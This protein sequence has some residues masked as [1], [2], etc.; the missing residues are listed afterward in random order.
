[1]S[2]KASDQ[3]IGPENAILF[4]ALL[5]NFY[6]LIQAA[7]IHTSQNPIVVQSLQEFIGTVHLLASDE[8]RLT[9]RIID[10]R[11]FF[12]EQKVTYRSENANLIAKVIKYFEIRGLHGL[13]L[14]TTLQL[15][16]RNEL[17]L[18]ATLLNTS[19]RKDNPEQWLEQ[20]IQKMN[21]DWVEILHEA[22]SRGQTADREPNATNRLSPPSQRR[23][24]SAR[25]GS[26]KNAYIGALTAL[27][28]IATQ[29][30]SGRPGGVRKALRTVQNMVDLIMEDE[31]VLLG[32]S[33]IRDFDDYTYVHSVNVGILAMTLGARIGLSRDSLEMIGICGL[34][35]DIGKTEIPLEIINKPGKLTQDEF[36]EIQK[37]VLY[38]VRLILKLR[39]PRDLKSK[40]II[41]PFE[42]HLKY[43]LSG[44]PQTKH[45]KPLSL[46]GRIISIADVYDALTSPRI[47]RDKE[48]SP[49]HALEIMVKKG[50]T[51][52]DP[53]LLKVFIKM[54]GIYPI[55][56]LLKLDS[57]EI[58]LVTESSKEIDP[59]R[60]RV[61]LLESVSKNKFKRGKTV[62]L[63]EKNFKSSGYKR[64]IVG[65]Y[66]PCL[67][68]IQPAQYLI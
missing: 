34:F 52:F 15:S 56:T 35:H 28:E 6:R 40:I 24:E 51:D 64:S 68:G 12:Q 42:H 61:V 32:L 9:I 29:V 10:G 19:E 25:I 62:S 65:S 36:E 7:K 63:S 41:A 30:T 23:P 54:I 49:N 13:S 5:A 39:A 20:Q 27:K 37:H 2:L 55:G 47:Y 16:E 17:L 3:R 38:S 53:I 26:G 46:H 60:P 58:G 33:T 11:L 31:V 43:D 21:L 50:G 44:Y 45:K 8:G 1:M 57:G 59:L 67:Y 66:H 18:F 14:S 4:E 48:I 22:P